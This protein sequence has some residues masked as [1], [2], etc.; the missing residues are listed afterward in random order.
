MK[1][2]SKFLIKCCLY[3]Y[4]KKTFIQQTYASMHF[5]SFIQLA[6]CQ[7]QSCIWRGFYLW[8]GSFFEKVYYERKKMLLFFMIKIHHYCVNTFSIQYLKYLNNIFFFVNVQFSWIYLC[9]SFIWS[10][11]IELIEIVLVIFSFF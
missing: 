2:F 1:I 9:L 11:K 4:L 5:T 8:G 3:C 10:I 6:S 7:F